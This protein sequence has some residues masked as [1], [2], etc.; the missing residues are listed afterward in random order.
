MLVNP[1]FP[2]SEART[3]DVQQAA[4]NIGQEL[5]ITAARDEAEIDP[6]SPA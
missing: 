1:N 3:G 2:G 6:G 4:R 5:V